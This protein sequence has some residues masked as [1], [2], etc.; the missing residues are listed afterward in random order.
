MSNTNTSSV[1][2]LYERVCPTP[3]CNRHRARMKWP[4]RDQ[5]YH[6]TCPDCRPLGSDKSVR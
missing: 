6:P 5:L 2:P 4:K 3:G 1:P